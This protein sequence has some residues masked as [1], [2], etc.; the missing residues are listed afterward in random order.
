MSLYLVTSQ[1]S[2]PSHSLTLETG[3]FAR[4]R[5]YSTGGSTP[6]GREN[7]NRGRAA[8]LDLLVT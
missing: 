5:A 7:G 2:L 3:S 8:R 1:A 4:S 6:A